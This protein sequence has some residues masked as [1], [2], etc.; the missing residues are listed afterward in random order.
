MVGLSANRKLCQTPKHENVPVKV[1]AWWQRVDSNHGPTDY[2]ATIVALKLYMQ[3]LARQNAAE[4][5]RSRNRGATRNRTTPHVESK[6]FSRA[7]GEFTSCTL[8]S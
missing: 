7:A 6:S 5:G 3:S 1:V 4:R 8:P 2:E